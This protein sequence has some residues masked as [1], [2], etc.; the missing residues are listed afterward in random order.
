MPWKYIR[1]VAGFSSAPKSVFYARACVDVPEALVDQVFPFLQELKEQSA[2]FSPERDEAFLALHDFIAL[3][4]YS[5]QVLCQDLAVMETTTMKGHMIYQQKPFNGKLFQEF[6]SSLRAK[7]DQDRRQVSSRSIMTYASELS[8]ICS[9]VPDPLP[10][11]HRSILRA[12]RSA[13][14]RGTRTLARSWRASGPT[15]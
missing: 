5:A 8:E 14:P 7:M 12:L 3:L 15:L 10:C 1:H 9:A 6:A 2:E 13:S 4:E 11:F